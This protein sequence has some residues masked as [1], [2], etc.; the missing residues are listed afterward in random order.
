MYVIKTN[1]KLSKFIISIIITHDNRFFKLAKRAE[2]CQVTRAVARPWRERR[3]PRAPVCME[4]KICEIFN[5]KH[6]K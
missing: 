5:I 6:T 2:F 3:M 1:K 4:R